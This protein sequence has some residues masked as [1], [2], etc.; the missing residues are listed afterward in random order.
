M[1]PWL[2]GASFGSLLY[3]IIAELLPQSY[4]LAGRT[5]IAVVVSLAAGMVAL[6]G[7]P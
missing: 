4:R 5:A 6:M 3:L 1:L 2:I 7:R